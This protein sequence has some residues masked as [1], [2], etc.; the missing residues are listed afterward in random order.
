MLRRGQDSL[1]QQRNENTGRREKRN[2]VKRGEKRETEVTG[3]NLE[4]RRNE[5]RGKPKCDNLSTGMKATGGETGDEWGPEE[6]KRKGRMR[7]KKGVRPSSFIAPVEKN[8]EL[9]NGAAMVI[10]IKTK[11]TRDTET[12]REKRERLGQRGKHKT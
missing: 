8:M 4:K 12:E 10:T 3:D 11:R 1:R 2:D 9:S 7:R 6:G 5:R